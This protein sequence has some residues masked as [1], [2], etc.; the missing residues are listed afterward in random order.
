MNAVAQHFTMPPALSRMID[1]WIAAQ[2]EEPV[3][4][5]AGG[6]SPPS[7]TRKISRPEAIRRLL[8]RALTLDTPPP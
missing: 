4:T 5:H 8:V 2:P 1:Q 7:A 6:L 3:P